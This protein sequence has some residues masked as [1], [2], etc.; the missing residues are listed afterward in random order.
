[1]KSVGIFVAFI[2]VVLIAWWYGW[3]RSYP[4]VYEWLGVPVTYNIFIEQTAVRATVADTP[5]EWKQ[6]LSG[7]TTLDEQAGMLFIFDQSDRYGMWMKDMLI[8]LDII[9]IDESLRIIYIEENVT[10]D[11][12]P[13]TFAPSSPARFVLEVPAFFVDSFD[14]TVGQ[15]VNLPV[16]LIPD[17][18]Q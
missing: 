6:G 8:P 14:I 1:M 17:D 2:I 18:L 16:V 11:T 4:I 3:L 10:P 13:K 12:Y 9:W 15:Q 7:V 5:A